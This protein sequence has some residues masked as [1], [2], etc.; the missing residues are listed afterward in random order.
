MASYRWLQD[1]YVNGVYYNAGDV[2]QTADVLGGTL[3]I[4]WQPNAAV[5]P[6]D[7]GAV[8]A[9]WNAGPQLLGLVRMQWSGIP[10]NPPTTYWKAIPSSG[11]T[12]FRL[13]GLGAGLPP[14][15]N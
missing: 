12:Q 11:A 15:G 10:V 7:T 14:L 3:P 13:T 8:Y 6:L 4:G 9:F 5:D 1:C 2:A